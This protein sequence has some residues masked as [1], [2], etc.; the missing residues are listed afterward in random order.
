[1]ET[2]RVPDPVT[3]GVPDDAF[4][5]WSPQAQEEAAKRLAEIRDSAWRPWYCPDN[6]CPGTPHDTWKWNHCRADQRP[7]KGDWFVW[8]MI[9][10]RGSGKTRGGAEWTRKIANVTPRIVLLSPTSADV[11]DVMVEGESGI[12]AV[13]PPGGRP[14]W[15]PSK[16]RLTWPNG[17]IGLTVSAEEPDR[18]RGPQFGA[19]W[20]DE[21]AH[22]S[23]VD[24]V[25]SNLMLGLRLGRKPRVA[26][27]TTPTPIPWMRQLIADPLTVISRASTYANLAN[28]APTFAQ[29]VLQ[30]YEGTRLG[31][32]ELHGEILDEAE[33]A[34]W[35]WDMLERTRRHGHPDLDRIII[36]VDPAGTARAKSDETGL[37]VVGI[38]QGDIYVLHDHSGR[39]SPNT[40]AQR[41]VSLYEN[42]HADAIVAETNYG[43][44]MVRATLSAISSSPRI[45]EVQ[46]RRGKALRAEPVVALFEQDKAHIV[47]TLPD[48]ETQMVTWV[49]GQGDSPDRVDALVHAV[50]ELARRTMPM[51][52]ANPNKLRPLDG[53]PRHLRA[54]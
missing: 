44:D 29:A 32:Q 21:P 6:Q 28:L 3:T 26:V 16:R 38:A 2:G 43:G 31:R 15:E 4:T 41:T 36:G 14:K 18:L 20:A 11:R 54:V 49:P 25:W 30:R 40:W 47:G 35:N 7:P 34:L 17:C 51:T 48:L 1:V 53:V 39:M 50:T 24:E 12:L 46:S 8:A 19:A 42:Y 37:I 52:V 22:Y 13:S 9:G 33:G 27:T 45:I 5:R 23:L 10:G